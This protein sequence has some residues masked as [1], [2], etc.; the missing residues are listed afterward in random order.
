MT[1]RT[2]TK[3]FIT[4]RFADHRQIMF[5]HGTNPDLAGGARQLPAGTTEESLL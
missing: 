3:P 5:D 1:R 2:S 4:F